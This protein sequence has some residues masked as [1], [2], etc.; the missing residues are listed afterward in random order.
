M[1]LSDREAKLIYDLKG[2]S[3]IQVFRILGSRGQVLVKRAID[4][5][6]LQL[7][8]LCSDEVRTIHIDATQ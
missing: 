8:S 7:V 6:D 2:V 1:R 3:H 5:S 4:R